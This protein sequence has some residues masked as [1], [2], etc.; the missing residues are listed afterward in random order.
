M[1]DMDGHGPLALFVGGRVLP[2][3]YPEA[4]SSLLFRQRGSQWVLDDAST[5]ALR[6]VGLV[7]GAA[8]VDLEGTGASELVLACEWGPVRIFRSERGQLRDVTAQWGLSQSLGWWTSV[9][10]GDFD[11]DGRLDLVVGNWGL[12][13]PDRASA[14]RPLRVYY[15]DLDRNGTL[16]LVEAHYDQALQDW[17]PS[18]DL[19]AMAAAMPFLADKFPTHHA[20][21]QATLPQIFGPGLASA[22]VLQANT[23]ATMVFLNRGGRFEAVPLPKEV[24]FSPCFGLAVADFD[25][26]GNEDIFLSQNFFATRPQRVRHDAGRGL[27]LQGDG[28]GHFKAIPG[29]DSGIRVYGE[30]RGCAV[31]DYDHDGRVD[32]VVTQNGA[33]TRLFHNRGAKPGLRVRIRGPASNPDGIGTELRLEDDAAKGPVTQSAAGSGYWSQDSPVQVL[34]FRGEPKRLWVRWPG[35]KESRF[36]LTRGAREMTIAPE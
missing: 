4:A 2:G 7:S 11:G 31:A 6:D 12:N 14:Q 8:W 16:D 28:H 17:V 33:Q 5:A 26:D 21:A 36:N 27:L 3:R 18:R 23:L 13:T 24:Q 25:G 29:Q 35:G 32:L 9:A 30:Q 10:A 15:G 22:K 19:V 20:Y 1:G 34:T